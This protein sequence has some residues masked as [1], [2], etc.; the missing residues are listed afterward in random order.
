[1]LSAGLNV[2]GI[3]IL[4]AIFWFPKPFVEGRTCPDA[5]QLTV[6][7]ESEPVQKFWALEALLTTL[8]VVLVDGAEPYEL[9]AVTEYEELADSAETLTEQEV[10]EMPSL[11]VQEV[12][13][14]PV[15]Q[16]AVSVTVVPA[17]T[18]EDAVFG[19]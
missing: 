2:C 9:D 13:G 8:I 5:G 18:G 7:I 4:N 11:Q 1:M 15:A 17:V 16:V 14:L 6:M 12:T 3:V 10:D 19:D